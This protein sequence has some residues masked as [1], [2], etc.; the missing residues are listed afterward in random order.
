MLADPRFL[1][2]ELVRAFDEFEISLEE[3]G[4]ADLHSVKGGYENSEAC[5]TVNESATRGLP[6][7]Q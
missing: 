3:H 5:R 4:G 1:Q 7:S 2:P 6:H